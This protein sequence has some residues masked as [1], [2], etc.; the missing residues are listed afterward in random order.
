MTSIQPVQPTSSQPQFIELKPKDVNQ[1]WKEKSEIKHLENTINYI[2]GFALV[3]LGITLGV[4]A[5]PISLAASPTLFLLLLPISIALVVLGL[6]RIENSDQVNKK[7]IL[8][9][10]AGAHGLSA[11]LER[12]SLSTIQNLTLPNSHHKLSVQDLNDFGFISDRT[13]SYI[14]D[15]NSRCNKCAGIINFYENNSDRTIKDNLPKDIQNVKVDSLQEHQKIYVDAKK[16]FNFYDGVWK[17]MLKTDV[18][19]YLPR[20]DFSMTPITGI[21]QLPKYIEGLIDIVL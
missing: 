20:P 5:A 14:L 15:L 17:N 18:V 21:K 7:L 9:T 6:K 12:A 4:I 11:S 10:P 13:F 8:A 19:P 16:L 2:A 1:I 3:I